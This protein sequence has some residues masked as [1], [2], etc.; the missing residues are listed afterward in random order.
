MTGMIR[1][2]AAAVP[3]YQS[4]PSGAVLAA[5]AAAQPRLRELMNPMRSP[6]F[7]ATSLAALRECFDHLAS[8][9]GIDGR[10]GAVGFCFG[11][12]QTFSLAVAEPRLRAA[13]S[14]YG[15][16]DFGIDQLRAIRAPILAFYGERDAG[17]VG[18]LDE[19]TRAMGAAGV[20]FQP[21]VFPHCGHAFFNDTNPYSYDSD[22]AYTAW[23]EALGFLQRS[24]GGEPS[25]A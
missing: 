25:G 7:A 20:D 19:L 11:G 5:R 2:G 8:Q 6:E 9:Q 13:V 4:E 23:S 16:G 14:F 17:L 18:T 1:V 12:A 21:H 22:A 24:L 10:I 3:A 15:R